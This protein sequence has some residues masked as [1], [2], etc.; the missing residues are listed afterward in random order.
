MPKN[1]EMTIA[2]QVRHFV[3]RSPSDLLESLT[4]GTIC[5]YARVPRSPV[6]LCSL[7]TLS[8]EELCRASRF[9][10]DDDR[11]AYILAHALKRS[12]LAIASDRTPRELRFVTMPGGKPML[13]DVPFHFNL[14]H[15]RGWVALGISANHEVGVDVESVRDVDLKHLIP[16]VLDV[17]ERADVEADANP[18]QAFLK[19]WT[20]KESVV[21]A[22]GVGLS[23]PLPALRT[24]QLVGGWMGICHAGRVAVAHTCS[25]PDAKLAVSIASNR[26]TPLDYLLL[27]TTAT[28]AAHID[29]AD[30]PSAR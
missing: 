30:V 18:H 28:Q 5:V 23:V 15:T 10:F 4:D 26:P 2:R 22:W 9:R 16:S 25:L 21:K 19:R 27:E 11:S 7:S 29:E 17:A 3:A 20:L 12:F 6:D 14:S 8:E 1:E 13:V 24:Q